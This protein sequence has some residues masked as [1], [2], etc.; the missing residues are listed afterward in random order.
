MTD[1]PTPD[2]P[3]ATPSLWARYRTLPMWQQIGIPVVIVAVIVL[4]IV[5]LTG[6]SDDS[7]SSAETS[8]PSG[9][10]LDSVMKGL[11]IVGGVP[12]TSTTTTVVETTTT[13]APTTTVPATTST[14]APTTTVAATVP[15]TATTVA[16]ATTAPATT[17]APTTTQ[18]P[19]T[20]AAP[21]TTAPAPTT[22]VPAAAPLPA[23]A[24]FVTQW[25]AA[26][27]DTNVPTISTDQA[28]ELTGQYAGYYL[29]TL[30]PVKGSKLPAQVGLIAKVTAPLSGQLEQVSL[31]W[32]PGADELASDFYW[33]AFGVLTQAV[34]PTT[35]PDQTAALETGL[36]KAPGMPPFTTT[37]SDTSDSGNLYRLFS[38]PYT[39]AAGGSID[40]SVI[41]VS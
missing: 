41:A 15:P 11:I 17:A 22:T 21:T 12:S 40:V 8:V 31:V 29:V 9:V 35:T 14:V 32:I 26:V 5:L 13:I 34:D 33:E 38:L 3:A 27:K 2:T 39:P 19:T 6:G 18:R 25:N 30:A 1:I 16:P 4:L 7:S 37:A 24:D 10:D 36:G 20:T 23:V 28:T